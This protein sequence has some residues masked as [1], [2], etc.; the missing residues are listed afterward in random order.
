MSKIRG[1]H[2]PYASGLYI[3][4][5]HPGVKSGAPQ[6]IRTPTRWLE[7]SHAAIEHQQRLGA[8]DGNRTHTPTLGR[9][10][11]TTKPQAHGAGKGT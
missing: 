11:S 1:L 6:G 7:A 10:N 2:R 3:G 4:V 9:S 8:P 5:D